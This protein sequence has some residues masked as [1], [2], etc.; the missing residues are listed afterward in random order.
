MDLWYF[1]CS[2]DM[3]GDAFESFCWLPVASSSANRA[4]SKETRFRCCPMLLAWVC[5][6]FQFCVDCDDANGRECHRGTQRTSKMW[7]KSDRLMN[8][9]MKQKSGLDWWFC[10][11][12]C[13]RHMHAHTR[14]RRRE[15]IRKQWNVR[16]R[17]ATASSFHGSLSAIITKDRFSDDQR[18]ISPHVLACV[19]A[20]RKHQPHAPK[21]FQHIARKCGRFEYRPYN[22]LQQIGRDRAPCLSV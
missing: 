13:T 20:V 15:F 21:H 19:C 10:F 1:V 12:C 4:L 7:K 16:C 5:W 9:V 22:V 2:G 3:V 6:W 18:I 17:T 11:V 8:D 14:T